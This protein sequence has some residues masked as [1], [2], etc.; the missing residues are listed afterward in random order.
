[1]RAYIKQGNK[2]IY[3]LSI[4]HLLPFLFP[5]PPFLPLNSSQFLILVNRIPP[6]PQEVVMARIYI[7][8]TVPEALPCCWACWSAAWRARSPSCWSHCC[9]CCLTAARRTAQAQLASPAPAHRRQQL[10]AVGWWQLG[11]QEPTRSK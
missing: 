8:D 1:M 7:P 9:C 10:A 6:S 11:Q 2:K 5:F 3:F 4:L